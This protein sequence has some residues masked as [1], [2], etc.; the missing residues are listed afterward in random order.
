MDKISSAILIPSRFLTRLA[1]DRRG[2]VAVILALALFAIVG[3]A[4]LGT[5]V[6]SWYYTKRAMQGAAD[7][8]ASSAAAEL[9]AATS[10]GSTASSTQIANT[11]RS[12]SATFHFTNGIS[13]TTV[14]VNN[15]PATTTSLNTCSFP[16]SAFNCYVEVL[17][18][19]PQTP[20]LSSLFVSTGPT[21]QARAVA[22]ANI[23]VADQGC[24]LALDRN[25]DV[26][27]QT[28]GSPS[29]T[30]NSCA[31][32]VNSSLDPGAVSMNGNP[33]ISAGSA[34]IVGSVSGSGLTTAHGL[35]TGVNP[36]NDPYA[37]ASVPWPSP[38]PNASSGQNCDQNNYSGG[39]TISA[40]STKAY[41]F[42]NGLTVVGNAYIVD[43]GSVD[44]HSG[45]INA[46]P[47][48]GCA[49]TGGVCTQLI[50]YTITF[51]GNS[52]FN[53]NCSSAGTKQLN[54]TN[55]TLVM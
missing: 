38:R 53:S 18:S 17:I 44:L 4:G 45:T 12:V 20:L 1:R 6:A 21:I 32:Y 48:S 3:F 33:S 9:A 11:G 5:E 19:Q 31:L 49:T 7:S 54:T 26:G 27:L 13:N 14:S 35:Y 40:S 30:F 47:S 52:T 51:K 50:A 15:P 42:C 10:A 22:L 55:G 24:V 25:A 16:F 46:P 37:S 39:G 23:A 43:Q 36:I 34:Y 29:L 41:V 8:A 2:T 28:S